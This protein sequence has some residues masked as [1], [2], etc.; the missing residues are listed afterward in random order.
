MASRSR[1]KRIRYVDVLSVG[2]SDIIPFDP[3]EDH[4]IRHARRHEE[5]EKS[6][7]AMSAWCTTRKIHLEI[8][9]FGNHWIFTA[10]DWVCEWWPSSAKFVVNKKWRKGIHVHDYEQVKSVL[11]GMISRD[12]QQSGNRGV[13]R[14]S[15]DLQPKG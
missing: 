12:V 5:A 6:Q 3:N 7:A 15:D 1:K 2:N 14:R 10:G 8:K 13:P 4:R 9:N 11:Q